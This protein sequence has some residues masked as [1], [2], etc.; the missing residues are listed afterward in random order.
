M[1]LY[2]GRLILFAS[3]FEIELW[4]WYQHPLG[5][6]SFFPSVDENTNNNYLDENME[7]IY[8]N[9]KFACTGKYHFCVHSL[10]KIQSFLQYHNY[11]ILYMK[12]KLYLMIIIRWK[13]CIQLNILNLDTKVKT[14]KF[15]LRK[16]SQK[17]SEYLLL[18]NYFY[19]FIVYMWQGMGDLMV[20][21][22]FKWHKPQPYALCSNFDASNYFSTPP[23]F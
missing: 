13:L 4:E 6:K 16:K 19:F 9:L 7:R 1:N 14:T 3:L 2:F 8:I 18:M 5:I 12:E 15:V 21:D 20:C 10:E 23:L 22:L 17:V 11:N